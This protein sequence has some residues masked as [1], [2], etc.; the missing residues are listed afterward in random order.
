M[1]FLFQAYYHK[2]TALKRQD[3]IRELF[4]KYL[5]GNYSRKE[6]Q[7]LL[8]YFQLQEDK[9]VL[10]DMIAKEMEMPHEPKDDAIIRRIGD[11]LEKSI[12]SITRPVSRVQRL[13]PWIS[14][15][16]ALLLVSLIAFHFYTSPDKNKKLVARQLIEVGPGTRNAVLTLADGKKVMLKDI[17][18]GQIV[19]QPGVSIS[20]SNGQLT[21][22]T[23]N[24]KAASGAY[25]TIETLKGGEYQVV[26]P[27]GTR[28]WLNAASSLKY[29]TSF[30]AL[31]ERRVQLSGEAYF[32]VAHNN[33]KPFRVTT[34]KQVVEVLGTHFNINS[35]TD[36]PKIVTTLEEGR[37]KVS[38]GGLHLT[39]SPG[40]QTVLSS[41]GN[42][43]IQ[44]ADLESALAWKDGKINFKKADLK[45]I[46]RQVERWYNIEV[47]YEGNIK[48]RVFTGGVSRASNLSALLKILELNDIHFRMEQNAGQ[49]KLIITP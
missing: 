12:F 26:L 15:A 13:L 1:L 25:N 17:T 40:Q 7:Q 14:T 2:K 45:T 29:P 46:M 3:H 9:D 28:V 35:Y 43:E 37:V 47:S 30:S 42:M 8:D 31:K 41:A 49:N 21:Y 23:S 24:T 4:D 32:Q 18:K 16:A 11:N 6:L 10:S 5:S 33:A 48:N 22:S 20:E 39:I 27:D 19:Q 38:S 44:Q 34:A 36:E